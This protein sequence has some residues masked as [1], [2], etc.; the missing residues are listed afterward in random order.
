MRGGARDDASFRLSPDGRRARLRTLRIALA[1]ATVAAAPGTPVARW[2][3][4]LGSWLV[5]AYLA[6]SA[7]KEARAIG[8]SP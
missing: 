8:R 6:W 7:G 2:A 4:L 5:A 1:L 3:D